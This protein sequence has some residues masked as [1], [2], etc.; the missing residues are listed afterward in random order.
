MF[1]KETVEGLINMKIE[2]LG[3]SGAVMR[4]FNTASILVNHSLLV[5]AGSASSVLDEESVG[6]IRNILITHT[7]IDHIKELPFIVDTLYTNKAK[8]VTIW[9]STPTLE[10]LKKH[11][12]NGLVWPE[13]NQLHIEEDFLKLRPVPQE[14]FQA[15]DL[16]VQAFPVDHIEGSVC[17]VISEGDKH[18]LFS[19]DMG[20]DNRLFDLVKSLGDDLLALFVEVSFPD[21]MAE[22]A[23]VSK[24]LTPELVAKGLDGVVSSLTKVIAYH[25]KPKH[26]DEVVAQLPSGVDYIRGG[27]VFEL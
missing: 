1:R 23:R 26:L 14:G 8:G 20:F 15:G 22:I 17:Y 2:I 13:L 19:G 4:G 16:R 9:G 12:F 10:A 21:S 24:H 18:V 7:H 27:E 5:D 11:I 25:I 3:C 6:E